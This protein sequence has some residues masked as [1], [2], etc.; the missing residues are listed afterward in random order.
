[1]RERKKRKKE[2][3]TERKKTRK[4]KR[5][6]ERKEGRKKEGRKKDRKKEGKKERKKERKSVFSHVSHLRLG[7][8]PH[9]GAPHSG[10]PRMNGGRKLVEGHNVST[11]HVA[12]C[13]H[14]TCCSNRRRVVVL[15]VS[16]VVQHSLNFHMCGPIGCWHHH[17]RPVN[18]HNVR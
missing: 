18:G 3:K 15:R 17:A 4:E 13:A 11:A 2:R 5:K 6:K 16:A 14:C 1:M 9:R 7:Y 12:R 8:W 10:H